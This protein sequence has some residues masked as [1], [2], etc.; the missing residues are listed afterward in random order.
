MKASLKD[1]FTRELK[2]LNRLLET[3]E[4]QHKYIVKSEV[5]KLE[6]MKSEIEKVNKDVA[7]IEMERRSLTGGE[8]VN[9]IVSRYEDEELSILYRDIKKVLN[10]LKLQKETNE[11]LIKQELG[12]TTQM[13]N[14]LNPK[15]GTPKT[16]NAYGKVKR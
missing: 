3:L 15:S 5:F 2:A 8:S 14:L 7:L 10:E 13:L 12:F 9:E 16:Y 6:K 4:E 1:I 11:V